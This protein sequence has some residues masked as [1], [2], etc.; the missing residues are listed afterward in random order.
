MANRAADLARRK[1]AEPLAEGATDSHWFEVSEP[2]AV[3]ERAENATLLRAALSRLDPMDRTVLALRDGEE[4]SAS[5]V[6]EACG[7][8]VDAVHKRLQRARLRLARELAGDGVPRVP[9]SPAADCRRARM[10]A[11]RYLDGALDPVTQRAVDEHLRR[12]VRCPPLLQALVGVR[13]ALR[14]MDAPAPA[15]LLEA[16]TRSAPSS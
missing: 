11:S 8:S 9:S 4:W 12:C 3:I 14:G 6:A 15:P 16:V 7:L 5:Q 10:A 13:A 2:L 1:I